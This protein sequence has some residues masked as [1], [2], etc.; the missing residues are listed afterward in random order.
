M[1]EGVE[2]SVITLTVGV[3]SDCRSKVKNLVMGLK[4]ANT[5]VYG[6]E[7][8]VTEFCQCLLNFSR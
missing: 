6:T 8:N 2:S 3:E 1:N 4:H 5:L 7:Y